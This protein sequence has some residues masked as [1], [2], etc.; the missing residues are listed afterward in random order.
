MVISYSLQT[1]KMFSIWHSPAIMISQRKKGEGRESEL[2]VWDGQSSERAIISPNSKASPPP[3]PSLSLPLS[4][5]LSDQKFPRFWGAE[6]AILGTPQGHVCGRMIC[7][8]CHTL[9]ISLTFSPVHCKTAL[10]L[11]QSAISLCAREGSGSGK[12]SQRSWTHKYA[13]TRTHTPTHHPLCLPNL[14][15][16]RG[17]RRGGCEAIRSTAAFHLRMRER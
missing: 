3:T 7:V 16:S 2:P 9:N 17:E 11:P 5:S 13:H 14:R 1:A 6:K 4:P 8:K 12:Q 15:G 10:S